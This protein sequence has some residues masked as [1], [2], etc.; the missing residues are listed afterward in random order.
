MSDTQIPLAGVIGSPISHSKSP[1]LH[2]YWLQKYNIR[3]HY[4]PLHVTSENLPNVLKIMPDMGFV[5]ANVTLPHK[6]T[7]LALSHTQTD[8]ARQIGA[9][10]TLSFGPDGKIHAD[11][12][13]A[14]GFINNLYQNAPHWVPSSG[15]AFVLGAGGASRAVLV[16][17]IHAGVAQ[18]FLANRT[19]SKANDLADEFGPTIKP[20]PWAQVA[21]YMR[22]SQ[23]IVNTTSLGMI[24]QPEIPFLN[25]GLSQNSIVTD[26]V[27]NP[28]E[29]ALLR[30]AREL[31]CHCVDGLGMLLHQAAPGFARW[32]GRTPDVDTATRQAVLQ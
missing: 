6:Q 17:L 12:T 26:I 31:G 9:A 5:G 16:A 15:P 4:I 13:D 7:A 25:K 28:L 22:I 29:T 20:V 18:I 32:F 30:Q 19:E 3:G 24:G 23:L 14:A 21:T 11:N 1:R 10:N 27:Y 2:G 8:I